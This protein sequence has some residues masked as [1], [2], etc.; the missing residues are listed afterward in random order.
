MS[1]RK[2]LSYDLDPST[3]DFR[4]HTLQNTVILNFH[5]FGGGGAKTF[6][7]AGVIAFV[8]TANW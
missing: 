2:W 3:I 5:F 6:T 7:R 8:D 4:A 1:V